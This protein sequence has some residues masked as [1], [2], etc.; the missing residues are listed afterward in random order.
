MIHLIQAAATVLSNVCTGLFAGAHVAIHSPLCRQCCR[1]TT[2]PCASS[3]ASTRRSPRIQPGQSVVA[4]LASAARLTL[5]PVHS[6]SLRFVHALVVLHLVYILAWTATTMLGDNNRLLAIAEGRA[7]EGRPGE[8][9]RM[10]ED[11][12]KRD[13]ARV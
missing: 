4:A 6:P 3:P 11:W 8:T 7:K 13:Q 2:P 1:W 9:R 10:L 12:G 5:T